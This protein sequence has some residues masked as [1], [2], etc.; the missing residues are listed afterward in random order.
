[1]TVL[2]YLAFPLLEQTLRAT[3]SRHFGVD[4]RITHAFETPGQF[5]RRHLY[6]VGGTCGNIGDLLWL[7]RQHYAS[8]KMGANLDSIDAHVAATVPGAELGFRVIHLWRNE[9]MHGTAVLPIIG[10]AV[11]SLAVLIALAGRERDFGEAVTRTL[12]SVAGGDD[13][14]R[15][16]PVEGQR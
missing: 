12:K 10:A 3:C 15:F 14:A 16:Y 2:A 13:A 9:T 8:A 5:T 1:L 7:Y 11:F 6:T 4:G